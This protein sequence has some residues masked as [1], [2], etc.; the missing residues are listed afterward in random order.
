MYFIFFF[1]KGMK[2]QYRQID[3][4]ESSGSVSIKQIFIVPGTDVIC[5]FLKICGN[6]KENKIDCF[7]KYLL[8]ASYTRYFTKKSNMKE[9]GHTSDLCYSSWSRSGPNWRLEYVW[10]RSKQI[11]INMEYLR[12]YVSTLLFYCLFH[13]IY[14]V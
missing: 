12:E 7:H 2:V 13:L 1:P 10:S 5:K 9:L 14:S 6:R 11:M 3:F 8:Y 4:K